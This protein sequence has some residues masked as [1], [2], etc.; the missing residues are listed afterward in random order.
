MS[1]FSYEVVGVI[2]VLSQREG[3]SKEVRLIKWNGRPEKV[4]IREWATDDSGKMSKGITLTKEEFAKL[5]AM[6]L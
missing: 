5:Q 2:G 3:W 4:D 1:D 6:S